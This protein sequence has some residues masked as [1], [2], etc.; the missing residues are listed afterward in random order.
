MAEILL[1][2][3]KLRK[4]YEGRYIIDGIDVQIE[5]GQSYALVGHSGSGKTTLLYLLA[6]LEK[7]DEGDIFW[8]G[9]PLLSL[10][11]SAQ[12]RWRNQNIGF[13]FQFF[14]LIAELRVWENVAL[15][16]VLSGSTFNRE[17][18]KALEWL[19]YVRL[20]ERA[21]DL[22]THLSGGEQQRVAIA[23][24]LFMNPPLILADE[25]TG[26]LDSEQANQVSHLF[27]NLTRSA[28][29][30]LLLATHNP[31]LAKKADLILRLQNGKLIHT[32]SPEL[33]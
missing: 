24:A 9:S 10:S 18:A 16:A 29:K 23:R 14:H 25:P 15:P 19:S 11:K 6:L 7:P 1:H 32:A 3:T 31:S 33:V 28:H 26:N 13:V 21:Y 2:A 8:R 5:A 27:F 4:A 20:K 12:A 22:P 17:K 30:A